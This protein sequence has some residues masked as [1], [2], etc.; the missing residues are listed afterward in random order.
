MRD[1]KLRKKVAN[2]YVSTSALT[3]TLAGYAKSGTTVC[4]KLAS[5]A[6]LATT[7]TKVN[8]MLDILKA[9]NILKLS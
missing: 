7:V 8:A 6:N 3:S 4:A 2:S 9:C 5:D 1:Y